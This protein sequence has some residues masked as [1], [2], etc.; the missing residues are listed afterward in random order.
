MEDKEIRRYS[1]VVVDGVEQA[2]SRA[3]LRAVGF[4]EEDFVKPQVGIA[5]TWSM[6]T[7]CNMH[8]D[9]LA[10]KAGEGTDAA[11]GKS[12]IFNTI[13]VSD[14]IAM[15]TPGMR[16]SLVSREILPILSRRLPELKVSM[17]WLLLE[18]AIK[19]CRLA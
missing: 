14:G 17:E 3:M 19:I 7:P 10:R 6:T 16:Y 12:V 18:V 4:K 9:E 8:I 15:G 1:A 13:S 2:P 5:S 11:G